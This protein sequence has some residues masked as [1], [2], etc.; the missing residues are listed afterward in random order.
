MAG[1]PLPGRNQ[2]PTPEKAE[3]ESVAAPDVFTPPSERA[4]TSERKEKK[5]NKEHHQVTAQIPEGPEAAA[6]TS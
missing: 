4:T 6:L 3:G 1:R 5:I 2:S